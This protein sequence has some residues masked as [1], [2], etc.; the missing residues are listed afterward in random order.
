[1]DVKNLACVEVCPVDCIHPAPED[2]DDFDAHPQV[3]IDPAECIDC[4]AC[5]EVC[6]VDAPVPLAL[7]PAAD[8][9]AIARNAAFYE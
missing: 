2:G 4:N 5:L 6:P 3:Y 1:M 8:A 7:V 9:S